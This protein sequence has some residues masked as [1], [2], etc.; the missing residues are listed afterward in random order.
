MASADTVK[1]ERINLRLSRTS[2]RRLEQAASVEGTT[3]S[4]FIVASALARAEEVIRDHDSVALERRDAEVFLDA[5]VNPPAPNRPLRAALEEH[6]RRVRSLNPAFRAPET[7]FRAQNPH[8]GSTLTCGAGSPS[9]FRPA[10][11]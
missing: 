6:A 3:V 1:S 8:S 9:P 7:V 11:R 5:I 4:G 10:T 2:K